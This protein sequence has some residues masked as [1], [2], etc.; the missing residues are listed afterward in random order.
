ME[1]ASSDQRLVLP[2]HPR[3]PA[4]GRIA[5]AR[6][7]R[8]AGRSPSPPVSDEP[9]RSERDTREPSVPRNESIPPGVEELGV[10]GHDNPRLSDTAHRRLAGP[11]GVFDAVPRI[12]TPVLLLGGFEQHALRAWS[13]PPGFPTAWSTSTCCP[14]VAGVD[15][16]WLRR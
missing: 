4:R 13:P 14:P 12:G 15:H 11:Q 9:G 10:G 8:R 6:S 2:A 7:E 5:A 1:I 16:P 3:R